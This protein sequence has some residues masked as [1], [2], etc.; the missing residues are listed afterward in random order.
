MLKRVIYA[1]TAKFD[2]LITHGDI[3]ADHDALLADSPLLTLMFPCRRWECEGIIA[4]VV[5]LQ[6]NLCCSLM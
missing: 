1:L 3:V 4:L 6:T 5:E 2:L